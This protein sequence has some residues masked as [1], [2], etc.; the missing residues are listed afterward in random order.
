MLQARTWLP[1]AEA[2]VRLAFKQRDGITCI[3]D[4]HQAGAGRARFPN[5]PEMEAEGGAQAVLLN[6]AGGL[7]G[8]DRFDIEVRMGPQAF[9]TVA[10][11]A[12]EKIYRARDEEPARLN[13]SLHIGPGA[14][15]DWLPQPTILFDRSAF[16]RKT[17]VDLCASSTFLAAECL[18]FGR[19]AMGEEL[20]SGRV[21]DAWRVRREGKLIFA[22][23]LRLDGG[24]ARMLDRPGVLVGGHATAT[25]FYAGPGAAARVDDVRALLEAAACD[26]GVSAFNEILLLRAAAK[27]GRT[28][29]AE[30]KPV[31]EFLSGHTLPRIWQC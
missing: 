7:T 29:Q 17:E 30:L 6:M 31:L 14:R 1:R 4:L 19:A 18:I 10:T 5:A 15:L 8:G 22:D 3:E 23:T 20:L 27:D 21:Q 26:I 28:L 13:V 11:A 25:I 16:V 2:V 12:A 24:V 9:A